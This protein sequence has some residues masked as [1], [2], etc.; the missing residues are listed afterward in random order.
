MVADDVEHH[1]Q[2]CLVHLRGE[3]AEIEAGRGQ[4]FIQHPE[5]VGPVTVVAGLAPVGERA[6]P[7]H[8]VAAGEG[9]VRIVD[10]WRDPHCTEAHL[11]DVIDV[12]HHALEVATQVA[13]VGVLALRCAR[14]RAVEGMERL[15]FRLALFALVVGRIAVDEA[16][17]EHEVHRVAG[18][19]LQRAVVGRRRRPS[20]RRIRNGSDVRMRAG[21]QCQWQ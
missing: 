21:G 18:H 7:F 2:P 11:L 3:S 4:V 20:R 9:L 10:D 14:Y 12:V 5:I 19:R 16:V 8:C 1:L 6:T 17:G 13:D 15:A